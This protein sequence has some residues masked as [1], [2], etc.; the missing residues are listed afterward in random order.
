MQHRR[1]V[2]LSGLAATALATSCLA[3]VP[4]AD[5]QNVDLGRMSDYI[6]A[7]GGGGEDF[8]KDRWLVRV[9]GASLADGGS[10]A[11]VDAAQ[12]AVVKAAASK[13]VKIKGQRRYSRTFNGMAVTLD[14]KQVTKLASVKGVTGIYPV[15]QVDRP[16]Q[17]GTEPNI[18]HAVSLSGAG[19]ARDDLGY[20]GR[21]IKV[22]VIDSGI[23]IDHPDLGGKGTN[24]STAFPSSRVKYGYDFVGDKYNSK[25]PTSVPVPDAVPDDCG[26]HGTHVAGIIGANGNTAKQGVKGVAPR[27]TFGGYRV[28]GCEGS[29]SSEVILAAMERAEADGMDVV[30]MSLGADMM[31]WPDY[32]TATAS[33]AM[34]RR[35]TIMV[36]SAGNSGETGVFSGGAPSVGSR[37]ISV[38]SY[39]NTHLTQ[40]VVTLVGTDK[41]IGYGTASPAPLPPTSGQLPVVSLG[42]PG[43]P[44]AQG[45]TAYT[46]E[47]KAKFATPAA[48]LVQR[49]S[50]T[51]YEKALNAQQ[52]GAK[53]VVLY[54]NQAGTINPSVEGAVPITVPV[55]IIS[56]AD[57]T[58]LATHT[59]PVIEWTNQTISSKDPAAGRVSSFSSWGVAADLSL[60][61]DLGAPGGN[62]WSTYPLEKG[63]HTSMSGT[64]MAAPHTAGAVA[65]ML[66]ARP[67]LKGRPEKVKQLLMNTAV[68]D[69]AWSLNPSL[70]LAEPVAR[71]GAGLIQVDRAIL[72]QQSITPSKI[73]LG[74]QRAKPVNTTLTLRNDSRR[75]V[76]YTL[77]NQTSIGTLGTSDPEFD[78]LDAQV[79]MPSRVVV[80]PRGSKKV[81]VRIQA[82]ADAPNGYLYGGWIVAKSATGATLNVPYA[83]M[84]GDYQRVDVLHAP[85][86]KAP[87]L[88][89]VVDKTPTCHDVQTGHSF[90][91]AEG[92]QP[93]VVFRIEYPVE[94]FQILVHKANPDG[95]K[96]DLLGTALELEH[97]GREA[98]DLAWAWDGTYLTTGKTPYLARAQAGD[99]I[100]ELKALRALGDESVTEDWQS[101]TSER[102]TARFDAA[103]PDVNSAAVVDP[104]QVQHSRR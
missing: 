82:P 104:M 27:V 69:A 10:S 75:P 68:H 1:R 26:G 13:G 9:Q 63:G 36:A 56:Q 55:V 86:S 5:A 46:D 59:N 83:G 50:C 44:Q 43:T 8:V 97:N 29:T 32:P 14:A 100:F 53:A 98:G 37:T 93:T 90:S 54:N 58:E 20:D 33:D 45:C 65:Q 4:T 77:T 84:A 92:D 57:G 35:G 64:S 61:P 91:M 48:A 38:A 73:S 12:Q 74:E 34:A 3:A 81:T 40:R 25:I 96:G 80:P 71:Q 42:A 17:K 16:A 95:S 67:A 103:K 60:K 6:K 7:A 30:N 31:T 47:Q 24:G 87:C 51:F 39:D 70:G 11:G 102:F 66:Q 52:A 21:G 41:K 79:T 2:L 89:L 62:I 15:V 49:G 28:F 85:G 99:Y 78:L 76:V 22:G 72:T 88:G 94:R 101:W 19:I 23:D 18:A